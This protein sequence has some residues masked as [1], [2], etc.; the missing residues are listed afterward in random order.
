ML[1]EV[2]AEQIVPTRT[3]RSAGWN[4]SVPVVHLVVGQIASLRSH[5]A[6]VTLQDSQRGTDPIASVKAHI[7]VVIRQTGTNGKLLGRRA[8]QGV[9]RGA[10]CAIPKLIVV[11]GKRIVAIALSV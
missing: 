3:F 2:H 4:I 9:A 6:H 1:T 7:H 11:R 5:V 8:V 10:V